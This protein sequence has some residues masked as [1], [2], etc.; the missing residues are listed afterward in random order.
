MRLMSVQSNHH[1][2]LTLAAASCMA[3]SGCV[4]GPNYKGPPLVA[5]DAV[6]AGAFRHAE[7]AHSDPPPSTWWL[8]MGDPQLNHLIDDAFAASPDVEAAVARLRQSRATLG[9]DRANLFPTTG[10]SAAYLQSKG[11]TSA[12]SGGSTGQ[13]SSYS[14]SQSSDALNVY[15]VGLDATWQLDLFG[16][17]RRAVEGDIAATQA[18]QA[19][20]E[21][22]EVSLAAEV[23]QDYVTLRDLQQR[24]ALTEQNIA[25]ESRMLALTEVR[26]RGGDASDLDVERMLNQLRSTQAQGVPLKAQIVDQLDRLAILTGRAPGDLDKV[27]EPV[28]PVPLPPKVV[29]V[30]D[31]ASLLRRRPDVRAAERTIQQKNA[32]IGQRTGD[33]FPKVALLGEVGYTSGD[34]SSLFKTNSFSYVAAPILQWSPLDFGRTRAGIR[35]AEGE[36]AEALANYRKTVLGALRDAETALAA[37]G[38]QRENLQSLLAVEA[39]AEHTAEL[40][41]RQVEGGAATSLDQLIAERDRVSAQDNVSQ[42]RAQLTLDFIRLEKSLGLGWSSGPGN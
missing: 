31:P 40:T 15:E 23:A 8:A 32:L 29:A 9:K 34:L 24:L 10:S 17:R 7:Q 42:A 33:L 6:S 25:V 41:A 5:P 30:G 1:K 18:V 26:R 20:L 37:Y 27:L 35:E 38:S 21:D 14:A 19:N 3:L 12:I 39:S 16:A 11:L 36:R 2:L 4:V 22:A 13:T 28:A